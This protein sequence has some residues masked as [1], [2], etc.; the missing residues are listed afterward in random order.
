MYK[1][2]NSKPLQ[3]LAIFKYLPFELRNFELNPG[4][5]TLKVHVDKNGNN[6][7]NSEDLVSDD[8]LV[9]TGQEIFDIHI[10]KPY[11]VTSG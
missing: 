4:R 10:R 2:I 11:K 8:L 9:K 3:T 7:I 5:Y 1:T 6:K